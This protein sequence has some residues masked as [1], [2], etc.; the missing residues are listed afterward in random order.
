MKLVELENVYFSYDK[1]QVLREVNLCINKGE[2]Y[3]FL[4]RSGSGKTTLLDL[5]FGFIQPDSGIRKVKG[6][7]SRKDLSDIAYYVTSY[8][9]RYFFQV[10]ILKETA[11]SLIEKGIP[12]DKA[13]FEARNSLIS[14]G[15][16]ESDLER[17]P[18]TLSKGDKRKVAIASALCTNSEIF[19][20]DEPLA[21]L[22]FN[23]RKNV[24]KSLRKLCSQE[25]TV[26]IT[27]H[28]LDPLL[29]LNPK[30][31]ALSEGKLINL[32]KS[33]PATMV[34]QLSNCGIIPPEKVALSARLK[35]VG[36]LI[37]PFVSDDKFLESFVQC[38]MGR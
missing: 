2:L 11:F 24:V 33:D 20:F 10:S 12:K 15:F 18:Q 17:D 3:V 5:I 28:I 31:F 26:V 35:K 14:L 13:Y 27:T 37:S 25:K 16:S 23:A 38:L 36:K 21:G 19:I 8:P 30:I 4:G 32:D 7:K 22:D 29:E 1:E 34:I 9:E 6:E